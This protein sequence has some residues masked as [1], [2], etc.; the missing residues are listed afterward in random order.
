M[1]ETTRN[2]DAFEFLLP[3]SKTRTLLNPM[4]ASVCLGRSRHFVYQMIQEGKLESIRASEGAQKQRMQITRR[5][6]CKMLADQAGYDPAG[7]MVRVSEIV[8]PLAGNEEFIGYLMDLR[9]NLP[10]EGNPAHQTEGSEPAKGF[11]WMVPFHIRRTL[12]SPREAAT[13]FNRTVHFIY[14]KIE[15][16][17]LESHA[18]DDREK[19]RYV[20][21]RGSIC[22]LLT[23]LSSGCS[24]FRSE[25][26]DAVLKSLTGEQLDA[27]S[28]QLS[29]GKRSR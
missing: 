7:F 14:S 5:S 20:V 21:T 15:E 9:E 16:G 22:L 10:A 17:S 3:Y 23:E 29:T 19:Q 18:P 12:L 25:R 4:E 6:V 27:L 13:C 1:I 11:D 8:R 24:E 28:T 26:L 2:P